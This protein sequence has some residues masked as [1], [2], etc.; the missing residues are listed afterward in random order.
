M[1]VYSLFRELSTK[2]ATAAM[3][4][5]R[6]HGTFQFILYRL[7]TFARS[8]G[9]VVCTGHHGDGCGFLVD[10]T[11]WV[12]A[13]SVVVVGVAVVDGQHLVVGVLH[14]QKKC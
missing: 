14:R 8:L 9:N 12:S 7:Q 1:S 4:F 6:H 11:T 10:M 13:A 5:A 2:S 3:F